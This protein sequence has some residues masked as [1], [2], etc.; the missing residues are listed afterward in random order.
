[1][2]ITLPRIAIR[3]KLF[4]MSLQLGFDLLVAALV[5][6]AVGLE[7]E[8]SGHATGPDARFAG[9]RTF[10]LLGTIGGFGGWFFTINQPVAAACLVGGAIL[11]TIVAYATTMQRAGSTVDGTTEVAAILVIAMGVTAGLGNRALASAAAA[12]MLVLLAEKSAFQS[13]LQRVGAAE[14]RATLQFAVLSLVV[15]PLLPAGEFGPY[16]AFQPRQLW[17]VVLL[18][19]ALSFAGYIARRL[20]GESRGLGITG[21]LGGLVSSTAVTISFSRRSRDEPTLAAPLA[22]GVAAACTV[23]LLR[24]LVIATVL[25]SSLFRELLPL[26]GVPFLVS[27]TLLTLAFWR[28]RPTA[29]SAARDGASPSATTADVAR[30]NGITNGMQNP[31][32]LWTSIQMAIAFQ[33]VLFVI[34]WVQATVGNP[35][36]LATAALLG[37]TDMDALTLSMTRLAEDAGQLHVA[38][39]AIGIGVIA[40][41][42][43]KLGVAVV[44]GSGPYRLRAAAS[45]LLLG[46]A[47]G[48]A[49]WWHW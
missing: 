21:L 49:L 36:V 9:L 35:G 37:L 28:E 48:I 19:S 42:V 16:G 41:T 27:A 40:N 32:A 4:G 11:F 30:T 10:A 23:L 45:L 8:W 20:V 13:A 22:F 1:V 38:A 39:S 24:V 6:L 47:S 2:W 26:L 25:R 17:S 7:R 18:F 46:A 43:L 12:V 34:A 15:L 5:G 3:G 29:P 33:L 14:L 44:L 31:L